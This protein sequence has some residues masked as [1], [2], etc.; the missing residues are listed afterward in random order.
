MGYF[1]HLRYMVL[2]SKMI[3]DVWYLRENTTIS[4]SNVRV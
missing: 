1:L 2:R 4:W 3:M